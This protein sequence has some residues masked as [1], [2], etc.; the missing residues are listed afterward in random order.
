MVREMSQSAPLGVGDPKVGNDAGWAVCFYREPPGGQSN[1]VVAAAQPVLRLGRD[2][3]YAEIEA[4]LPN[5]DLNGGTYRLVIEGLIDDHYE[6]I[7]GLQ[8]SGLMRLYLYWRDTNTRIA[9]YVSSVLGLTDLVGAATLA[10]DDELQSALVAE[11]AIMRVAR[12]LGTRRYETEIQGIERVTARLST[13]MSAP[14]VAGGYSAAAEE[15]GRQTSVSVVS[16]LDKKANPDAAAEL[17]AQN[18]SYPAGKTRLAC[19]RDLATRVG[20][21]MGKGQR[22]YL[23]ARDGT[24]Y[25]GIRPI[26]LKDGD[27]TPLDLAGGLIEIQR[28]GTIPRDPNQEASSAQQPGQNIRH[29]FRLTLKGRPDL[30]PGDVVSFV[31]PSEDQGSGSDSAVSS[32]VSATVPAGAA[33]LTSNGLGASPITAY[34]ESVQHRLGRISSFV[35]VITCLEMKDLDDGWDFL[36]PTASGAHAD[37]STSSGTAADPGADI[38]RLLHRLVGNAGGKI[39]LTEVGEVRGVHAK[40]PGGSD[41]EPASQTERVWLGLEPTQGSSNE[42]RTRAVQRDPSASIEGVAYA[43]P[44]AWGKCGLVLPRYPGTRVLLGFRNGNS[45]DPVDLGSVWESGT[46]PDSHAGDW[47]LSL[48]AAVDPSNRDSIADSKE[49]PPGYSDKVTN[50]L[51]DADGRRIIQVDG[52]TIAV[53]NDGLLS[54]GTRPDPSTGAGTLTITH[55][56]G[57]TGLILGDG[58]IEMKADDDTSIVIEGGQITLKTQG[59]TAKLDTSKLDVS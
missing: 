56:N 53:G 25:W 57:K 5:G 24:L 7:A 43:S 13:R 6:R 45:Y 27:P 51:T 40:A 59:V 42:V 52:L 18:V 35:T 38:G 58:R 36:V 30:K 44:F 15:V 55:S 48:P 34:V 26:P 21:R 8:G 2:Q 11:I 37:D 20:Q 3:Y 10:S 16:Y 23:L 12:R 28:L 41:R 4:S 17:D 39:Q 22:G 31:L 1:D 54:A 14:L 47:W 9:G 32:I 29:Q 33:V 19:L 46:G 49:P 50:D